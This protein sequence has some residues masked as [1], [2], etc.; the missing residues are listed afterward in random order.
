MRARLLLTS[1]LF[2]LALACTKH[3]DK[4]PH[5]GDR[6]SGP[7]GGGGGEIPGVISDSG[8]GFDS[9]DGGLCTDLD[10]TAAT[11][12]ENGVNG[13]F[14]GSGGAII[15]GTYD[16]VEVRLYLGPSGI[17]GPTGITYQGAVRINGTVYE[18]AINVGGTGGSG[19][20]TKRGT[21]TPSGADS[22]ATLSLTCP[23]AETDNVTYSAQPNGL[24]LYNVQTKIALVLRPRA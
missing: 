19:E 11:V 4:P 14:T 16:V 20:T 3:I 23:A 2:G 15:D 17:G 8:I 6:E 10:I 13:D 18:S 7:S 24:T 12:E 21:L 5:E 9:G 22:T 1:V